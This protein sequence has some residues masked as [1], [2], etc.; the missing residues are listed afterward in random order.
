LNVFGLT[1]ARNHS[2]HSK[3]GEDF[4]ETAVQ[5]VPPVAKEVSMNFVQRLVLN[6]LL[7]LSV[8]TVVVALAVGLPA[9][10]RDSTVDDIQ[11]G[12]RLVCDTQREAFRFANPYKGDAKAALKIVNAEEGNQTACDVVPVVYCLRHRLGSV[13]S[14]GATFNVV[15]ILVIGVI[16]PTGIQTVPPGEYFSALVVDERSA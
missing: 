3:P 4:R 10:A 15:K 9:R 6:L 1:F 16:T 2:K 7:R 12:V 8:V 14:K 5:S 11:V 13:R